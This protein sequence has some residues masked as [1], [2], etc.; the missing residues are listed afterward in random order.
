MSEEQAA[1]MTDGPRCLISPSGCPSPHE[2]EAASYALAV[3]FALRHVRLV[4]ET[5]GSDGMVSAAE[6]LSAIG[7]PYR[8][9]L[10]GDTAALDAY[11]KMY[12]YGNRAVIHIAGCAECGAAGSG[13][14]DFCE[15][16]EAAARA[17][18]EESLQPQPAG[19]LAR[20][21]AS[22]RASGVPEGTIRMMR[23]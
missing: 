7:V 17:D 14:R 18:Y 16:Y 19:S 11:R 3:D 12:G 2:R 1:P 9:P 5:A 6:V 10:P 21:E 23:P 15:V 4:A 8:F 22:L 20:R 13:G